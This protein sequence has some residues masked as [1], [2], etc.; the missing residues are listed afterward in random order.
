MRIGGERADPEERCVRNDGAMNTT[1]DDREEGA[2]TE[3]S[4]VCQ[5]FVFI[6]V[7]E[8]IWVA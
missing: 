2:D 8:N 3:E 1:D 5:V 4:C 7:L 6:V